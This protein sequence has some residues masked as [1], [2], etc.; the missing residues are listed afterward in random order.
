M[1][2]EEGEADGQNRVPVQPGGGDPS[3]PRRPETRW[4]NTHLLNK[5]LWLAALLRPF[6][7]EREESGLSGGRGAGTQADE[8]AFT[9]L[10][11]GS[12]P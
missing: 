6:I 3:A 9:S 12:S 4:E 5:T 8:E 2:P 10:P 7:W 11:L 1:R